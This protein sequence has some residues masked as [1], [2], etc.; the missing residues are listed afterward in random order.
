MQR[1]SSGFDSSRVPFPGCWGTRDGR[2][3]QINCRLAWAWLCTLGLWN[4]AI[5]SII[6]QGPR[7]VQSVRPRY[8]GSSLCRE[9]G[10]RLPATLRS[11]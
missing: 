3:I 7:L 8:P 5:D 9:A 2:V 1:R 11:S 10:V 6:A 4:R